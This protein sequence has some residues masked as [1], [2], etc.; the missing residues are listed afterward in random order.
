MDF[1]IAKELVVECEDS[2]CTTTGFDFHGIFV[3]NREMQFF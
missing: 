1:G 2:N 3:F